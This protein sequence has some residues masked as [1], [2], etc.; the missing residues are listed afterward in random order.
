MALGLHTLLCFMRWEAEVRR[1]ASKVMPPI[2]F[3]WPTWEADVDSMAVEV[4]PSHC[5]CYLLLPWDRWQQRAVWENSVWHGSTDEAKV[6]HWIPPHRKN[7]THWHSLTLA[8]CL[9]KP[10][11]GCEHS[12]AVGDVFQQWQQTMVW[13]AVHS[14]HTTKWKVSWSVHLCELAD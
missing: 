7:G 14:C 10:N 11:C 12:E 13:T 6:C 3:C 4:D 8:E 5:Y 2:L 9:H 1:A